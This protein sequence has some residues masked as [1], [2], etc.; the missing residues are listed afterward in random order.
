LIENCRSIVSPLAHAKGLS[1]VLDLE[2]SSSCAVIGDEQ[3]LRQIILNLLNNAVKFTPSG[4]ITVKLARDGEDGEWERLKVSINDTGIGIPA[5]QLSRLFQ[6]FSQ[7][8]SS[9]SRPFGG[10]GLGLAISKSLVEL[11]GGEIGVISEP[12]VRHASGRARLRGVQGS[13]WPRTT[14][15]IARSR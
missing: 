2:T 9:S 6:R 10:T 7:I 12:G 8:D 3:R 4:R 1:L 11:M 14:R 15:S 13:C 5:E